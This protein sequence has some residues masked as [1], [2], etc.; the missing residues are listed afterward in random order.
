MTRRSLIR[1]LTVAATAARSIR[2]TAVCAST[3]P[4]PRLPG[5]QPSLRIRSMFFSPSSPTV[6]I[7]CS[8][9]G[10]ATIQKVE[11]IRVNDELIPP[12]GRPSATGSYWESD[13]AGLAI[14]VQEAVIHFNLSRFPDIQALIAEND[15]P[16]WHLVTA[17]ISGQNTAHR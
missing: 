16:A 17:G 5:P 1:F 4:E 6:Q 15:S 10:T 12:G 2:P 3:Y 14:Y 8:I 11:A 13:P 7:L 9:E